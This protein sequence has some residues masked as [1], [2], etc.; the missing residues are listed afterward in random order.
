MHPLQGHA[1]KGQEVSCI[2][3]ANLATNFEI[4]QSHSIVDLFWLFHVQWSNV[5]SIQFTKSY[6]V[7]QCLTI[8]CRSLQ[9]LRWEKMA[10]QQNKMNESWY[11]GNNPLAL[12]IGFRWLSTFLN[13]MGPIWSYMVLYGP[14]VTMIS[15]RKIYRSQSWIFGWRICEDLAV[16]V[17]DVKGMWRGC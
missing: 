8:F 11:S 9:I 2:E 5:P 12:Y 6:N 13:A 7:S 15:W 3:A 16:L 10:G 1:G 4:S 17:K 14:M